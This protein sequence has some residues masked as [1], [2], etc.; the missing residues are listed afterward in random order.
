MLLQVLFLPGSWHASSHRSRV[1]WWTLSSEDKKHCRKKINDFILL[2]R[3]ESDHL[4][5][6][7]LQAD[8]TLAVSLLTHFCPLIAL[9]GVVRHVLRLGAE[10]TGPVAVSFPCTVLLSLAKLA[11]TLFDEMAGLIT[12]WPYARAALGL[13]LQLA[14]HAVQLAVLTRGTKGARVAALFSTLS[15]VKPT[16]TFLT[17]RGRQRL[18]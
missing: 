3:D 11:M 17:F 10:G 14:A 13:G 5:Q 12:A 4:L 7:V 1:L 8:A 18:D 2:F 16:V 9:C 15:L 6:T